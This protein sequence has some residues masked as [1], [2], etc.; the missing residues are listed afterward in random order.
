MTIA[1]ALE[2]IDALCPNAFTAAEKIRW[3]SEAEGHVAEEIVRAQGGT[4]AFS[5]YGDT[6]D[7]AAVLLAPPP[8]DSLYRFYAEAQMHY[9]NGEI[10]RCNNAR[11][12]WNNAFSAYQAFYTRTHRPAVTQPALRLC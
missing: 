4:A 7:T 3:L 11:S 6:T 9:V 12:E 2:Q 5:G 1:Q 10:Q 8:Y